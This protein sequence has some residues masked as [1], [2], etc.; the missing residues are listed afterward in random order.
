MTT[1][2]AKKLVAD[3]IPYG[4]H[5][6]QY[7]PA[8][9]ALL[10]SNPELNSF[11]YET[12][13][14]GRD[15][16]GGKGFNSRWKWAVGQTKKGGGI[17]GGISDQWEDTK[18]SVTDIADSTGATAA[19]E[20]V[21][22]V[23][24]KVGKIPSKVSQ[25][26][27]NVINNPTDPIDWTDKGSAELA[28]AIATGGSA[29]VVA[30]AE[31]ASEAGASDEDI[32]KA[33]NT[34]SLGAGTMSGVV[35]I[36]AAVGGV[37]ADQTGGKFGEGMAIGTA[38]QLAI[39]AAI[40]SSPLASTAAGAEATTMA[41]TTA[42]AA[43]FP[44]LKTLAQI[45]MTG[46][47]IAEALQP[48]DSAPDL[49]GPSEADMQAQ[50]ANIDNLVGNPNKIEGV[51]VKKQQ[52]QALKD[53]LA[54]TKADSAEREVAVN[55]LKTFLD[56]SGLGGVIGGTVNDV[57]TNL[58][59]A[60]DTSAIISDLENRINNFD[61]TPEYSNSLMGAYNKAI[62]SASN[63]DGSV[64]Y[65][66]MQAATGATAGRAGGASASGASAS[67]ASATAG[68]MTA[69]SVD[70]TDA[71]NSLNG[72]MDNTKAFYQVEDGYIKDFTSIFGNPGNN[73]STYFEDYKPEQ[74]EAQGLGEVK[75]Q[76]TEAADRVKQQL[77]MSGLSGS[78]IEKGVLN[79]VK[80]SEAEQLSQQRVKNFDTYY[81]KLMN[82]NMFEA[83]SKINLLGQQMQT[84]GMQNDLDKTYAQMAANE[85]NINAQFQQQASQVN[86]SL[87][88]QASIASA[89]NAT[90]ASIASANNA[91]RASIAS[92]NN[93]TQASVVNAN[94]TTR[95]NMQNQDWANKI[96][97]FNSQ[98]QYNADVDQRNFNWGQQQYQDSLG[99]NK[100]NSAIGYQTQMYGADRGVALNQAQLD[101][102]QNQF[103]I[104][105]RNDAIAGIG[106]LTAK[107]ILDT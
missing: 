104:S 82:Y 54:S 94:N 48:G 18:S 15:A 71:L 85:E 49:G 76:F 100:Y 23:A 86:A 97:M 57:V 34:I 25:E 60:P 80:I 28:S 45:G 24:D 64:T 33:L 77:A 38:A 103:N 105:E 83:Q 43:G 70:Y 2:E 59:S 1:E 92:A 62:D 35:P 17:L 84:L 51:D 50:R 10:K 20:T 16:V 9:K 101:M 66:P 5:D 39:G 78:G 79:D 74:L 36:G 90:Q 61:S 29:Y 68:Q 56:T 3:N 40:L 37:I 63:F 102:Q 44:S 21:N 58:S 69:A 19:V 95:V 106:D 98:M 81:D 47:G 91:T 72:A 22:K 12:G 88:T 26:F 31:A 107:Y 42:A 7:V 99:I 65:D 13:G 75:Q 6:K 55:Q 96:G 89:S 14:A 32:A 93:A 53:K 41:E 52:L 11:M 67:G 73:I 8:L 27:K 46:V 87:D 30:L 4:L